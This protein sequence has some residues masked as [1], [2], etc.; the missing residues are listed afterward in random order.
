M[1]APR[2]AE[3]AVRWAWVALVF[4]ACAADD[5]RQDPAATRDIWGDD[6][7]QI[8][9]SEPIDYRERLG[10]G[11]LLP[12]PGER[13]I[14]DLIALFPPG[15]TNVDEAD[16]IIAPGIEVPT[17]Q[18]RGGAPRVRSELPME[19]EAVV[20]LHPR[21][22]L[23]PTICGQDERNYGTFT[24]EDDTGGIIV[25]RDSRVASFTFG[26]RIKLTVYGLMLTYGADP[27]TR[28]VL[29]ADIEPL[30]PGLDVAVGETSRPVLYD[31]Q[32]DEFGPD[33]VG[34]TRRVE[35]WVVVEPTNENF[36]SMLM[37]S[38][39]I[40]RDVPTENVDPLC[41]EFCRAACRARCNSDGNRVCVRDICPAICQGEGTEFDEANLPIC[42]GIGIDAELGRRGFAPKPGTH[43]AITGPVV[44]NFGYNIWVIRLGQ[45]EVLDAPDQ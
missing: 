37:T 3:T 25:I 33:D 13:G 40:E 30:P 17:D 41:G 35:G 44:N 1:S 19:I 39:P 7:A 10:S 14:G 6:V 26:D 29:I 12:R 18:C 16:I 9:V 27:D 23:K 36:N 45:A 8:P 42:W 24:V 20:T 32:D 4:S 21:Q 34:Y 5:L 43:I 2:W 28:A 11:Y 38:V 22:Y 15:G 31:R